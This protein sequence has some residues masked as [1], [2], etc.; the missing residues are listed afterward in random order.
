MIPSHSLVQIPTNSRLNYYSLWCQIHL[1]QAHL[2][3]IT[4]ATIC[5]MKAKFLILHSKPKT[6]WTQII[7]VCDSQNMHWKFLIPHLCPPFPFWLLKFCR[8]LKNQPEYYIFRKISLILEISLIFQRRNVNENFLID[9]QN[10]SYRYIKNS[11]GISIRQR[12]QC[13]RTVSKNRPPPV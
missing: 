11:I 3:P 6:I 10:L 5:Q 1:S 13:N 8:F 2:D 4:S 7:C 9:Y 12:H